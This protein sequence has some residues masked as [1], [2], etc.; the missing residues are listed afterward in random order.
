MSDSDFLSIEIGAGLRALNEPYERALDDAL[1]NIA[2]V[3]RTHWRQK[4]LTVVGGPANKIAYIT[5][6]YYD[7]IRIAQRSREGSERIITIQSDLYQQISVWMKRA[8][9]IGDLIER[10]RPGYPGRFQA[11]LAIEAAKQDTEAQL[12]QHVFLATR[13]VETL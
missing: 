12:D 2:E 1:E 8:P 13:M 11:E 5:G 4:I 6:A 3:H 9:G 7:S 10:G